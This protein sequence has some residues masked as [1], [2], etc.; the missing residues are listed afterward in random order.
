M[1]LGPVRRI[2]VPAFN[3][4]HKR[5]KTPYEGIPGTGQPIMEAIGKH[6]EAKGIRPSGPVIWIYD[7]V[8][9][10]RNVWLSAGIPVPARAPAGRFKL[11]KFPACE[12][13]AAL[14]KG[15]ML[16]IH[17]AW[18]E[19]I[20]KARKKGLKGKLHTREV[21][22]KWIAFDSEAHVTLLRLRIGK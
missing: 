4:L 6:V 15:S 21:Y 22:R 9:D 16:G 2:K 7:H 11:A 17:A 12:C 8:G 1:P 20:E 3:F 19:M 10:D 5:A 14:Y 13:Y 18:E